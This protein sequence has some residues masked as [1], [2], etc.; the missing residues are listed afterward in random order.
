MVYVG[1][2]GGNIGG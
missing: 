1:K 2:H